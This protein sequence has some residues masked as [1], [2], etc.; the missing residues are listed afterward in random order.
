LGVFLKPNR[1]PFLFLG[2]TQVMPREL[3]YRLVAIVKNLVCN[4]SIDVNALGEGME[5]VIVAH[6]TFISSFIFV[7][8]ESFS[9]L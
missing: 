3:V 5:G 8:M 2:S 4:F 9:W 7:C 1:L 6:L